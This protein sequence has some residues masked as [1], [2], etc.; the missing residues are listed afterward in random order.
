MKEVVK[1]D[2][3]ELTIDYN[4]EV[5]YVAVFNGAEFCKSITV[6]NTGKKAVNRFT[7]TVGGFYFPDVSFEIDAIPAGQEILVDCSSV[8]PSLEKLTLLA[9]ATYSE[10]SITLSKTTRELDHFKIPVTIQAWN[11]WDSNPQ[12]YDDIASFVMPN[13]DYVLE[14]MANASSMLKEANPLNS[15]NGYDALTFENFLQQLE[16]VWNALTSEKIQYLTQIYNVAEAGQKI[17]TVDMIKRF[18]QGNCMDLSLL[19]CSCLER[20]NLSPL[21]IFVP[22]HVL[23]G[24]WKSPY[25]SVENS[26]LKDGK[27]LA[28]M[29]LDRKNSKMIVMEATLFRYANSNVK[30]AIESGFETISKLRVD[31]AVDIK[32]ARVFGI[33]PLPFA[34]MPVDT[35][36]QK[37]D[38][39][40]YT[41][42]PAGSARQD[43]W[44]RKLLD[45]TLRNPMLNLKPGKSI[46]TLH[47]IDLNKTIETFKA[48]QLSDLV[49]GSEKVKEEGLTTIYRASR[50][51]IEETG[52]NSLFCALG[53]LTW[54]DKDSDRANLSPVIFVPATIVRK[55][56]LTYEIRPR[57]EEP[58]INVTLVEMMRQ[59]FGI[60]FPDLDP[61]PTDDNGFPDWKTIFQVFREQIVAI[62]KHQPEDRQWKLSDASYIGI[63]SFTKFL[64][65]NDIHSHP[66]VIL[67]HPLIKGLIDNRYNCGLDTSDQERIPNEFEEGLMMPV[68]FDSSQLKAI[69]EAHH[70]NSFVLYGPPGTGKSQTITNMIA[71]AIFNGKKVLFVAEKKAA[72]D[73]VQSR[74]QKIGLSEFCLELHSNKTDKKSFFGQLEE[75][76]PDDIGKN[77]RKRNLESFNESKS[78]L[79]NLSLTLEDTSKAIHTALQQGVSVYEAITR[80]I[81]NR[82]D[83]ISLAYGEVKHLGQSELNRLC[84]EIISLDIVCE[85]IGL[86]PADSALVGL[87]PKENTIENQRQLTD[88][89][90]NLQSS[91][92][93]ARKKARGILNRLFS[94]KTPHEILKKDPLWKVLESLASLDRIDL[95]DIDSIEAKINQWKSDIDTLRNW[96]YFSDKVNSINSFGVPHILDYYLDGKTGDHTSAAFQS[97]YYRSLIEH[98][99][100]NNAFLRGFNGLLHEN[101]IKQY[102]KAESEYQ[103]A[104][105]KFLILSIENTIRK[106]PLTDEGQ[107]QLALLKKRMM[108]NGRRVSLR[109]VISDSFDIIRTVFPCM[110]MSPLSVAQYLEMKPGLF[111]IIIFD[112]ASQLETADAIGVIARGNTIVVAGDPKQLPPTRFFSSQSSSGEEPE[113][114][115]DA[116]SILEDCITLGMPSFYLTRHYRSRHESLI[117]FSNAHFYDNKLLTFPSVNDSEKK[118]RFIDPQGVYD[119]GKS[120]TNRIEAEAVVK[121]IINYAQQHDPV[122][123]IGV[124]AF[125]KS[126]SN[127]IEDLLYSALQRNKLVQKKLEECHEPLFVKNLENV[128]GDERDVI[129]F[130]IGYGPDK[131]GNVSLNFGPINKSGGERRLNVAVS[132]AREEMIVFSSLKPHHIPQDGLMSTGVK[133]MRRFLSY[134]L[135]EN[136]PDPEFRPETE[137]D[138]IVKQ[139]ADILKNAGWDV[140]TGVGRSDFKIDVAVVDK[141]NPENYLLGIIVDGKNYFNLPTARDR[142]IVVPNVLTTLGWSLHR[143]WAIDWLNN[144][145]KVMDGVIEALRKASSRFTPAPVKGKYRINLEKI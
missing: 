127:L 113:E 102:I 66:A 7:L 4:P 6:K 133:T 98:N 92:E 108:S 67:Q 50:L 47:D 3:F 34:F 56:A 107:Q 36:S 103:K 57:D 15:M 134:A 77:L 138:N 89:L 119:M 2:N 35:G 69:Y 29:I 53:T 63:F 85:L 13:H 112:E 72:L 90:Q 83:A 74:L 126:Q 131:N 104:A 21:L 18:K 123:S 76:C 38:I 130:S 141:N 43:G 65:W 52:A 94:K 105:R 132:R 121:F 39:D 51:A 88:T 54:Y 135:N 75:S 143:I 22:G 14:L 136:L 12:R 32:M 26:V 24:L 99:L 40:G 25:D 84:S 41:A 5:N 68:D 117:S 59:L 125:S 81:E 144:P 8:K 101:N 100:N 9:E 64:M 10:I 11:Y 137:V 44:E 70:D 139:V 20:L 82:F 1:S 19:L 45:I 30:E 73:V 61:I 71:D 55:K 118:V 87:Y 128:Q 115:E 114:S 79:Q 46:L 116:D 109:K 80:F 97:G 78:L 142:E 58:R 91:I 42:M 129:I 95:F 23:V 17:M 111:D 120:R 28:K 124:V 93:R 106:H 60:D 140:V 31:F 122:P 16:C 48:G 37:I 62:N 110:L 86:H 145:S 27:E 96:Y 49:T 33:K